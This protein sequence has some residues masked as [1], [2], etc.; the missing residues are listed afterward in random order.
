[1]TLAEVLV[2]GAR[3]GRGAQMHADLQAAGVRLADHDEQEPLRLAQLRA[4][5]SLKLPDCCVLDTAISNNASLATF[6]N[7]LATAARQRRVAVLP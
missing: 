1:I 2:G 3:I 7:A 6:D 5:T 4:T